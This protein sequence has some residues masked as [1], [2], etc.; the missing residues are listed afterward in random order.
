MADSPAQGLVDPAISLS[1]PGRTG[2]GVRIAVIDSG[3]HPGHD[4]IN[5][6]GLAPG[7]TILQDGAIEADEDATLDRLGH[8]TAVTAVIQELARDATCLPVRVFRESLRAS[9][10]ALLA[11][12]DWSIAQQVDIV[13]LSLGTINAAHRDIFAEAAGRAAEA[14]IVM[15][16]A[17]TANEMPCY[18][19]MLDD[20]LGTELDWDCPSSFYRV[21]QG[22]G[23]QFFHASGYPRPIP[24]VPLQRNLYGI[25][26]AVA[27]MA[28]FAALA[29][30]QLGKGEPQG[31]R[32]DR[33]RD[34]LRAEQSRL[35]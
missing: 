33:V 12:I 10:A 14:G 19:G 2:R 4:H 26:F 6:A 11:A 32:L 25:S 16:A 20:V 13:N 27:R 8:G 30:E 35:R 22:E 34:L 3:V 15:V 28:G 29:C 24:G 31:K 18:P 7:V 5:P 1:F 17:R 23:A 21:E 9:A